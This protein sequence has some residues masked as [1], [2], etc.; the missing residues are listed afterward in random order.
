LWCSD[1]SA[2]HFNKNNA[3]QVE[4]NLKQE[5]PPPEEPAER[6]DLLT[7]GLTEFRGGMSQK[8]LNQT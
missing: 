7:K 6:R 4:N 8:C 1:L 5:A 3:E 2:L